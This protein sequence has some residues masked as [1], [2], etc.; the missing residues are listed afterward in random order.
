MDLYDKISSAIDKSEYSVGVFIDLSKAFD[1]LDHKILLSKLEH[2]GIRGVA[3]NWF[4]SYLSNRAQFVNFNNTNSNM[5][6]ITTG[7]PQGSILGPLLFIL[8]VN[9]M[10][11]CSNILNLL[12]FADDTNIFHSDKDICQLMNTVN[13]EL[14]KLSHWFKCNKLSLNIK[15]TNYILFGNKYIPPVSALLSLNI[16]GITLDRVDDTKFLGVY[17]DKKLTWNKHI[18]CIKLQ[19]SKGLGVMTRVW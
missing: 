1:T 14:D 17:I 16:D 2:Y 7:V 4:K 13:N 12:L 18:N 3:L 11:N 9:D 10:S 6:T 8:Y 5:M 19:I 15:K